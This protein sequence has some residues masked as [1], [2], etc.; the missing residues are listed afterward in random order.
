MPAVCVLIGETVKGTITFTEEGGSTKV[1]GQVTGLEP[2]EHG[3]HIHQVRSPPEPMRSQGVRPP[4]PGTG[5]ATVCVCV[6]EGGEG[7]NEDLRERGAGAP[8]RRRCRRPLP[9]E[10]D[11]TL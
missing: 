11:T 4:A 10:P 1:T 2:G 3:F 8:A 9:K 5:T 7:S 6:M